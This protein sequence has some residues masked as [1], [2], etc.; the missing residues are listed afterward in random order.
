[1]ERADHQVRP[2]RPSD[3][4]AVTEMCADIWDHRDGDYLPRVYPDWIRGEARRTLVAIRDGQIVGI[5]QCVMLSE[6]EAWAQ[7]LR[8]REEA[9][10][11]GIGAALLQSLFS[12]ADDN[13]AMVVRSMVFSWNA[14]G[15]GI[16]RHVGFE[17]TMQF[18]FVHPEPIST[19][20]ESP[21]LDPSVGWRAWIES[22]AR[23][24]LAGL[25]LDDSESWAVREL[26]RGDFAE[27]A[28]IGD[29]S[30]A[31]VGVGLRGRSFEN[32]ETGEI[33]QEYAATA[34]PDGDTAESVMDAIRADA[35]RRGARETRVLVPEA[36]GPISDV[37]AA[38]VSIAD[39]PHFV[40]SLPLDAR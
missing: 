9:R 14:A 5:A 37:A 11:Q 3:H 30:A 21:T 16:A 38:G 1:M 6:T 31:G 7:G 18:R 29:R 35:S 17:P 33:V 8:V 23:Q 39:E 32:R 4:E 10:G 15:L 24:E 40:L 13:G 2:A 20:T 22:D 36:V 28:V 25:G 12:W 27:G 34:W 26:C 19:A